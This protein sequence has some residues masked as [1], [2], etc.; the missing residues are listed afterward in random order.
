M[1][2]WVPDK[3]RY[4]DL[5]ATPVYSPTDPDTSFHEE[6]TWFE[7]TTGMP[8]NNICPLL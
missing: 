1:T 4:Q 3:D 7:I 2:A 5:V 6:Y 8:T